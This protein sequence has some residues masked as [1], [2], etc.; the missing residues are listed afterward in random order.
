MGKSLPKKNKLI[1]TNT[2]IGV[3]TVSLETIERNRKALMQIANEAKRHRL[4]KG[5][6]EIKDEKQ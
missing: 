4:K 6:E 2:G 3:E 5:V 1:Y